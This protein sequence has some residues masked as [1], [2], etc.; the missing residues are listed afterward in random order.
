WK[1]IETAPV[2]PD[3]TGTLRPAAALFR[4][5]RESEELATQWQALVAPRTAAGLVH[6]KWHDRLRSA[7]LDALARRLAERPEEQGA[8][9]LKRC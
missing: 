2:I 5:P 9:N 4:H 1:A 6:A 7:R 8:R 3:A